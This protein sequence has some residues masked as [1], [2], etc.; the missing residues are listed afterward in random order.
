MTVLMGIGLRPL[1]QVTVSPR[2]Y[3]GDKCCCAWSF[4]SYSRLWW[5]KF[6]N[7]ACTWSGGPEGAHYMLAIQIQRAQRA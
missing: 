3:P 2:D 1:S 4:N 5:L 6:V 7:A